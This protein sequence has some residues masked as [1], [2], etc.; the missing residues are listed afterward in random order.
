MSFNNV[1]MT[2]FQKMMNSF[3]IIASPDDWFVWSQPCDPEYFTSARLLLRTRRKLLHKIWSW[4]MWHD[5]KIIVLFIIWRNLFRSFRKWV[6]GTYTKPCLFKFDIMVV[7][8]PKF[9][10]NRVVTRP[11]PTFGF[12]LDPNPK[13]SVLKVR[14]DTGLTLKPRPNYNSN[15]E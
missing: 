15:Y 2:H 4:I 13:F 6:S 14:V 9:D 3:P 11:T 1:L 10:N 12:N 5:G 7:C 8:C